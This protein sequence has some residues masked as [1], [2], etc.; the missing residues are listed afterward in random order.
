MPFY[1]D[2]DL[3]LLAVPAV[4]LASEMLARPVGARTCPAD[5]WLIASWCS[6][7]LWMMVNPGLANMSHVN[8]TVI[9]LSCVA[10]LLITR[11]IRGDALPVATDIVSN[12]PVAVGRI[13]A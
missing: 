9:L 11:A 13:A 3:L 7:F 8:G 1:F 4:L 2:Y 5:R 10:S 6:L 12:I